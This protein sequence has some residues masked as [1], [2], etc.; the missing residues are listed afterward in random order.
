MLLNEA[1]DETLRPVPEWAVFYH[2]FI[3]D[4]LYDSLADCLK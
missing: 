2:E 4:S 3:T 1:N